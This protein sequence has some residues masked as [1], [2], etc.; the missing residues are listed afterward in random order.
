MKLR[1]LLSALGTDGKVRGEHLC[2]APTPVVLGDPAL[3]MARGFNIRS[4]C[5]SGGY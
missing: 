1:C 2:G 5:V 3:I 4:V